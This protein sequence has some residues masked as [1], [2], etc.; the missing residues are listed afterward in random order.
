[1]EQANPTEKTLTMVDRL[2]SYAERFP[3]A[4]IILRPSD[5]HIRAHSDASYASESKARS[6]A[7]GIIFLGYN[8]DGSVNGAFDYIST[9]IP[10]VCSAAAESEY[11]ALFLV[12]KAITQHRNTLCDMGYPQRTTKI[13]CDNQCAVGIANDQVKQKHS[14]AIDM[15]YHWIRD[16]VKQ[17]KLQVVWEKGATN[18]ADY[19][20]KAYSSKH[21]TAIRHI[22]VYTSLLSTQV[23]SNTERKVAKQLI[24][25]M[26]TKG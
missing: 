1:M 19:F 3:N 25:L 15:R 14:R 11:A 12:G 18:L 26:K 8:E 2:L 6:R 4:H 24:Y 20:T 10:I 9:V 7:G 5:M 23:Q 21:T 13:S 17:N 22:Y 16:Q